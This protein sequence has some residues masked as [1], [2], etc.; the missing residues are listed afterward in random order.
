MK[1]SLDIK[2]KQWENLW[3]IC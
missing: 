1:H 2:K 3:R